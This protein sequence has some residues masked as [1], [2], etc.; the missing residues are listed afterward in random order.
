MLWYEYE[1]YII[2]YDCDYDD[3][4][5]DGGSFHVSLYRTSNLN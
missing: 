2:A 4:D 3:D 5:E 1:P